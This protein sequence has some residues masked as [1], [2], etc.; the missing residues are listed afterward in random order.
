ML[1][2]S[3]GF[4][5]RGWWCVVVLNQKGCECLLLVASVRNI[6]RAKLFPKTADAAVVTPLT[7]V[8]ITLLNG[9]EIVRLGTVH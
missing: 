9:E 3:D 2:F 8:V 4:N 7:S 1:K 6:D 5:A